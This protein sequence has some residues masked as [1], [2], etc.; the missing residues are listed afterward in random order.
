MSKKIWRVEVLQDDLEEATETFAVILSDPEGAVLGSIKEAQVAIME[1]D[2]K[3]EGSGP[4]GTHQ[5]QM[6]C[7]SNP[8]YP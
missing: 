6:E 4:G 3:M 1:T 5:D 7:F 8:W 2:S